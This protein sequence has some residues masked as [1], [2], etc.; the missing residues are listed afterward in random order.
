M[1]D[2]LKKEDERA[3][4]IAFMTGNFHDDI[5][6]IYENLVDRDYEVSIEKAKTLITELRYII[7]LAQE[8]DF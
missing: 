2:H 5:T 1:A 6:F 4:R 8:D 7:K 3:H